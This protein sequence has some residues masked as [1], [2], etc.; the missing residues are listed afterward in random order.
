[1][2]LRSRKRRTTS[3]SDA[4][5]L[6][7][8]S[9]ANAGAAAATVQKRV[10]SERLR[11]VSSAS[12]LTSIDDSVSPLGSPQRHDTQQHKQA[13]CL[14]SPSQSRG[15]DSGPLVWVRVTKSGGPASDDQDDSGESY[16]W[17]ARIIEGR[18]TAGPLTVSLYGEI[19]SRAPQ[20]VH[21]ETPSPSHVLPFKQPG[22]DVIP[23]SPVTFRCRGG[24]PRR[25]YR[26]TAMD[27]AWR[28]AVDLAHEADASL[29][30]GLPSNLSSYRVGT[31]HIHEHN[32]ESKTNPSGRWSPPP[33]DPLL[34][35]P[36]E[37]V[38]SLEKKGKSQYW[39]ARVEQYVPPTLPWV[40]PKY[41]VRFKDDTFRTVTRDMFYT[42]DEPEFY[43][44]QLGHWASDQEESE[45]DSG[46]E[47]VSWETV[48][49]EH[50]MP[51]PNPD[52]FCELPIRDQFAYI[53][54][55]IK[56]I[57]NETYLPARE[58]HQA[59]MQGGPS[60]IR[61]LKT[62]TGKGDLS[63][64]EVSQLGRVLQFWVLGPMRVQKT[65][66]H[67]LEDLKSE[68]GQTSGRTTILSPPPQSSFASSSSDIEPSEFMRQTGS[69]GYEALSESDKLQYC[70]LVL[71]H[72]AT[73]QLL[74]WRSGERRSPDLLPQ[75]EEV[76]LRAIGLAKS[77][78]K[79][80]VEEISRMR[81]MRAKDRDSPSPDAD[82]APDK[83]QSG[84]SLRPRTLSSAR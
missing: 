80:W 40:P 37:L 16:W 73:L 20:S 32:T 44:C 75:D 17:P 49:V 14:R 82:V 42:S 52:N 28:T 63:A 83:H 45:I 4:P 64:H 62:A 50:A 10:S 54:P 72:E 15:A 47:H 41:R 38:Y 22:Q 11:S 58:R 65:R 53:K 56:A 78:E 19:S 55:V 68:S 77:E 84:R 39:A 69:P 67:P 70:L 29:N 60:R 27:E 61:L 31:V 51:P 79:E 48:T 57:L 7:H 81:G 74:L 26:R 33:C 43:T 24:N 2:P 6:R 5:G 3:H 30:D 8:E 1:M 34:E 59:F 35:I 13:P 71:F 12:S 18:L 21:L 76:R 46:D 66:P 36:G 25:K 23:F 9:E